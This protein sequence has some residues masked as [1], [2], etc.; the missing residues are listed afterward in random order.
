MSDRERVE[1]LVLLA[2][3]YVDDA[4]GCGGL[5]DETDIIAERARPAEQTLNALAALVE[6]GLVRRSCRTKYDGHVVTC[7]ALDP[8]TVERLIRAGAVAIA[9]PASPAPSPETPP[10]GT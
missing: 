5:T 1:T 6:R 10:A 8:E 3:R 7:Y 9:S 4:V 2:E